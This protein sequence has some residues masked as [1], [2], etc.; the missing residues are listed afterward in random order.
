[1]TKKQRV[2][3]TLLTNLFASTPAW[4]GPLCGLTGAALFLAGTVCFVAYN[5]AAW[6]ALYKFA[7]PLVGLLACAVGVYHTGLENNAGRVLSFACGLFIGLFWVVFG[8]VYQTG[9]FVYEFCLAWAITLL[10]LVMLAG[11]RWLWLLWAAVCNGYILSRFSLW[12]TDYPYTW[13]LIAFN[14]V[15]FAVSEWVAQRR[16]KGGWFSL[17]FLAAVLWFGLLGGIGHDWE[18]HFWCS[19]GLM[20][21]LGLY[22]WRLRRGAAQ[23]GFCALAL[24]VLLASQVISS[25][26]IGDGILTV[27]IVM[28]LFVGS[29]GA[30]YALSR[31]EVDHD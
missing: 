25:L 21:F 16:G 3:R 4:V 15:C 23:L 28:V 26:N 12:M 31:G 5:W 13:I 1:M 20:L 10:P 27:L 11:N 9:A 17:F 6:G 24:D 19:F 8:Q 14:V 2:F 7:L 18:W 30:V 22:A 29:G